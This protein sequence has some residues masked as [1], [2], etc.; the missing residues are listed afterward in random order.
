MLRNYCLSCIALIS[1]LTTSINAK[2]YSERELNITAN[3]GVI[4]GATLTEP[5][6]TPKAVIVLASGSGIQNRDEEVAGKKP[7][8]ALAE[9]LS[10]NGY[11]VL[12]VDD[13]GLN[14]PKE[15]K[16]AVMQTFANDVASAV[17]TADS[18][19]KNIPVGIIGHSAGGNYAIMNAINNP[20]VD[21]IV[22]L[23]APAW[24]GDSII[25]SQSRALAVA[26]T[27]KWDAEPIQRQIMDITK[28]QM[29][30]SSARIALTYILNQSMGEQA[31]LPNVSK[32]INEQVEALLS[33]WYRDMLRYNPIKDIAKVAI[34][35]LAL[36]GSKDTQVLPDNLNTIKETNSNVKTCLLENHNHL[37]QKCYSGL[38]QEYSKLPE[39]ISEETLNEI[40]KWLDSQF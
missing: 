18:I 26:Y 11:S 8:R 38:V 10:L 14:N 19:Y 39:D 27:G 28:S 1:L 35:W 20:T 29:K 7:F 16:D 4:M 25:I 40:L 30:N 23:A 33:P 24:Q 37:F 5:S 15:A 36:N 21:F 6:N 31:S 32:Y 3:D 22:T 17:S 9:F 34:P 12:R 2:T 13:R